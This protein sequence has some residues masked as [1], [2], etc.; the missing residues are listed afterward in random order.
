VAFGTSSFC[1]LAP[2]CNHI[3]SQG[4]GR[5]ILEIDQIVSVVCYTKTPVFYFF[6][7]F[8]STMLVVMMLCL[9]A[10]FAFGEKSNKLYCTTEEDQLYVY[11]V[12]KH[13]CSCNSKSEGTI[14]YLNKKLQICNG[15]KYVE[16]GGVPGPLPELGSKN[17]PGISCHEISAKR[18]Y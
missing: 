9:M 16:V 11:R 18:R 17:N 14:R 15:E 12:P 13:G 7:G 4:E 5:N 8:T 2:F 1:L 10:S 6:L 3:Q